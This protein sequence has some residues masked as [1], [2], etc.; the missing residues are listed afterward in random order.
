M[1]FS[2]VP[3]SESQRLIANNPKEFVNLKNL[4]I[5]QHTPQNVYHEV[6]FQTKKNYQF[7]T[8]TYWKAKWRILSTYF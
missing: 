6:M 3:I 5:N 4:Y 7:G 1:V 8:L 2:T